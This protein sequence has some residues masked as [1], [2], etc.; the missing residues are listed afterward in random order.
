M[1]YSIK[2]RKGLEY[3]NDLVS[4]RNQVQEVRL[5]DEMGKQNFHENIKK[6]FETPSDPSKDTSRDK[7]STMMQFSIKTTK[8]LKI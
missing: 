2:K 8:H 6:V 5:Q 4:L 3:L 7:T 1:L